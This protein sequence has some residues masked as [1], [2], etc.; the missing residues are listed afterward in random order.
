MA[1]T[2]KP[3]ILIIWGDDIGTANLSIFTKGMMATG[4]PISIGS[5][6][7][8]SCSPTATASKVA[9]LDEPRSAPVRAFFVQV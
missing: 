7:K 3:N 5:R 4:V 6:M 2:K 9:P 1:A 8:G